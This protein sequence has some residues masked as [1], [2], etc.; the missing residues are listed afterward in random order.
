MKR[1]YTRYCYPLKEFFQIYL[2]VFYIVF[3]SVCLCCVLNIHI[4]NL[5]I[6]LVKIRIFVNGLNGKGITYDKRWFINENALVF[7]NT[8]ILKNKKINE[9]PI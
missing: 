9:E 6:T 2:F 7:Y 8:S 3:V 1:F 4:I 5:I